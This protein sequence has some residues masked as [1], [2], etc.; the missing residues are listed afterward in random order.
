MPLV[1]VIIPY[2]NGSKHIRECLSSLRNQDYQFIEV[3]VVDDGSIHSEAEYLNHIAAEYGARVI[4]LDK[5]SGVSSA[6]NIGVM[7]CGGRYVTTVDCDDILIDVNFIRSMV[8]PL[9]ESSSKNI[10]SGSRTIQFFGSFEKVDREWLPVHEGRVFLRLLSR[11]CYIPCNIM[12]SKDLFNMVG[13][14]NSSLA[15]YEDWDFKLRLFRHS[16]LVLCNV[17]LGYRMHS[18][19]LSSMSRRKKIFYQF[20]VFIKNARNLNAFEYLNLI[21]ILVSHLPKKIKSL[22]SNSR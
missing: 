6:R 17:S 21:G 22:I 1:S 19:G 11:S 16:K 15:V 14:Y 4:T 3:I 2:F 20:V 5:N 18:F 8:C 10:I 7:E 13:G 12:Y 9:L